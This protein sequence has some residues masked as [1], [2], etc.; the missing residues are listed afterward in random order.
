MYHLKTS[1]PGTKKSFKGCESSQMS[2]LSELLLQKQNIKHQKKTPKKPQKQ[3][4]KK[5][6]G[7]WATSLT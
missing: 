3:Q 4:Q 7:P 5:N 1:L 2:D 6:R